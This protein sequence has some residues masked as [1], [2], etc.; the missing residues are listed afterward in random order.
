MAKLL[1]IAQRIVADSTAPEAKHFD[2][3]KWLGQWLDRPQQSE[4]L[5]G[6]SI[7]R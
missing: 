5:H 7:T 2:A 6:R 3:A 4:P 1:G